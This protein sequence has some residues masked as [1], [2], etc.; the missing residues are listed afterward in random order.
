MNEV[1]AYGH[2]QAVVDVYFPNGDVACRWCPL[3]LRYEEA[4]RRYS[5]RLSGEWIAD[6]IHG[7]GQLCPLIIK[8]EEEA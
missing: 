2:G 7:R 6:P 5:C 1:L 4:F 8:K 3:F